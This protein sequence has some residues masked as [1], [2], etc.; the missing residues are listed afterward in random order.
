MKKLVLSLIVSLGL[1]V[2]L[3]GSANALDLKTG[4][5]VVKNF[6]NYRLDTNTGICEKT[7]N[8]FKNHLMI[9]IETGL[10]TIVN[11][12][13]NDVGIMTNLVASDKSGS[14]QIFM[15]DSYGECE[16]SK[17]IMTHKAGAADAHRFIGLKDPKLK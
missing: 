13:Q 6:D 3:A 15:M 5:T 2:A 17:A 16:F 9:D 10:V 8:D 1:V 14:V 4:T 7:K 11:I 12:Y